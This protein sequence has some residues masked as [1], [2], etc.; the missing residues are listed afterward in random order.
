MWESQQIQNFDAQTF[1]NGVILKKTIFYD[2]NYIYLRNMSQGLNS[3]SIVVQRWA[4]ALAV[5]NLRLPLLQ[6]R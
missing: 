6:I 4:L 2:N 3:L 1:W 5:F